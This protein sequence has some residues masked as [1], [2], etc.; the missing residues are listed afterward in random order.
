MSSGER[1]RSVGACIL[2]SGNSE[3]TTPIKGGSASEKCVGDSAVVQKGRKQMVE[4]TECQDLKFEFHD[5]CSGDP[6]EL[7]DM[8]VCVTCTQQ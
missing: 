6:L 7:V 5:R 2:H 1:S 4:G 8:A 3:K